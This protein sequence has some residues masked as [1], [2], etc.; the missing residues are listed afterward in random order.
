MP[1]SEFQKKKLLHVY[2]NLYDSNHDS[3]IDEQDFK[4]AIEKISQLHHW[5]QNDKAYTEAKQTLKKIWEGLRDSADTN[6][7][8]K[9]TEGEWLTMWTKTL[10]AV[11]SG[12]P[13]PDWQEKYTDFMFYANDTSGD[14]FIDV[15]EYI[16]IQRTFGNNE[17]ESKTAFNKLV[18]GKTENKD[19]ISKEDFTSLW[20]E[21]FL[22]NDN[23]KRG[24]YLFGVLKK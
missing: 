6:N 9:V 1:L 5:G 20:K 16:A 15:D 22:S 23:G 4:D 11:E 17:E 10:Q 8:G 19:K 18:E 2:K 3:I 24:N 21:Y 12:Q 13:F 7:D 14:G